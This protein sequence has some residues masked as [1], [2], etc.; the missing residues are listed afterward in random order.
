M[1]EGNTNNT[2]KEVQSVQ[3]LAAEKKPFKEKFKE[4]WLKEDIKCEKC[5]A[6]TTPAKGIN[7][8][9]MRRLVSLSTSASDWMVLFMIIM[10]LV[11]AWAYNH[12]MAE[13][14]ILKEQQQQQAAHNYNLNSLS[15]TL[16][17]NPMI[18]NLN[19]SDNGSG[20]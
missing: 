18:L 6:V 1:T 5:G 9:N 11:G 4:N 17:I 7:R 14:K 13:C 19:I 3:I 10:V 20:S 15:K 8:Q 2:E 12:D 16:S